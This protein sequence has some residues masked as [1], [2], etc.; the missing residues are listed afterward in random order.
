[1]K[2]GYLILQQSGMGDQTED[3]ATEIKNI[4]F[5]F[6]DEEFDEFC[7]ELEANYDIT[8]NSDEDVERFLDSLVAV[9]D[10]SEIANIHNLATEINYGEEEGTMLYDD[11]FNAKIPFY[12]DLEDLE[13][14]DEKGITRRFVPKHRNLKKVKFYKNHKTKAQLRR[15]HIHNKIEYRTKGKRL[16]RNYMRKSNNLA[17]FKAYQKSRNREIALGRHHVKRRLGSTSR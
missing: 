11:E 2:F 1:M 4:V 10:F 13:D 5:D 12:E 17:K 3:L 6:D 8:I 16:R 9:S 7:D 14:L 15:E